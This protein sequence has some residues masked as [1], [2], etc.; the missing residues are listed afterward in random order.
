MERVMRSHQ[1]N[2]YYVFIASPGDVQAERSAVRTY[3]NNLN[4]TT[5]RAWNVRFQVIDWENFSTVGVGRPQELITQ[6]TLERFRES[7]VLV[8]VIMGQ[9]FGTPSGAAESGTEEE[10]RWALASNEASGFP[11]VKFFF[12]EIEQFIA[13]P[14]PEQI[15]QAAE[16]WTRVRQFRSEIEDAHS[17]LF[18]TYDAPESFE[19]V[20]R[21]DLDMW[22]TSSDRSWARARTKLPHKIDDIHSLSSAYFQ[23]LVYAFQ[24][25]DIAGI[26]TDRAFKLPLDRIYV[27]LRV[28]SSGD[29]E[30]D[31]GE[32]HEEISIQTA[33]KLHERLA[34][35]GDPGSGKSTFLRFTALILARCAL[36]GDMS[37]ATEELSLS[38]PLPIPLFLSCWDLAEFLKQRPRADLSDVIDFAAKCAREAGWQISQDGLK[39]MLSDNDFILLIDGLDEIPTEQGRH[40]VSTLIE[41]FVAEYSRHRYVVT[42]RV[43]AYTGETVLGQQFV[44]YDIQPFATQERNAFLRTG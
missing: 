16:Q 29:G 17:I 7:L 34:I 3:F 43:R 40:M 20:L 37:V 33:L 5:A 41:E 9:R 18:K 13:P 11:E 36:S 32:D 35:V 10:V 22:I 24:W 30:N 27:R 28:I 31:P 19:S 25:L 12:R 1:M 44:R 15:F 38:A 6:Q 23:H 21:H 26:D 39:S 14:D 42:S 8:I 4:R 2:E